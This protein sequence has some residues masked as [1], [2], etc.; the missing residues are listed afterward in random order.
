MTT[1]Q[2]ILAS[3]S[4][5]RRGQLLSIGLD[6]PGV[7]PDIDET[8]EP[9]EQP[10]SL[11]QRLAFEKANKVAKHYPN[12]I[13]IGGDQVAAVSDAM[14]NTQL[15]G[16]P[17]TLDVAVEQLKSCSGNTVS[18]FTALSLVHKS[19]QRAQTQIEE[20]KVTFETLNPTT[21]ERYLMAEQPYDCAGSFKSEGIGVLLF[22]HI[23]SR[24]PN[25]LVGMPIMLLRDMLAKWQINLL[26]LV[27][28]G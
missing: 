1:P 6:I 2:L 4:V 7:S 27:L 25:T 13:V 17:G 22:K 24:D 9:N 3:S 15:L 20:V 18:F 23:E 19:A 8:P 26:Q 14:G 11:A 16:K 28:Q 10:A 5:Y 21:I 12:A